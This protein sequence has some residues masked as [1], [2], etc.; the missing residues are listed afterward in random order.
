MC[1]KDLCQSPSC[2]PSTLSTHPRNQHHN[3][4]CRLHNGAGADLQRWWVNIQEGEPVTGAPLTISCW[5]P[6]GTRRLWWTTWG[7]HQCRDCG[8][9]KF[10]VVN[11]TE[12]LCWTAHNSHIIG[13]A[14][15]SGR[16]NDIE[17]IS[18]TFTGAQQRSSW[19]TASQHSRQYGIKGAEC[20]AEGHQGSPPF[21]SASTHRQE[22][23]DHSC[24]N[25]KIQNNFVSQRN[26]CW[27][28]GVSL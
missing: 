24:T 19:R 17:T 9:F 7:D 18:W 27:N 15:H 12:D 11:I 26:S 6:K 2:L 22:I 5:T 21:F 1:P 4:I 16:L 10:L 20:T 25:H 3:H 13:R 8:E 28:P 14:Q 23:Q